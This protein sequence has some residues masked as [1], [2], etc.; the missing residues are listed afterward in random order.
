MAIAGIAYYWIPES[1]IYL[2]AMER[3]E[4][5]R[6][7]IKTIAHYNRVLMPEFYYLEEARKEITGKSSKLPPINISGFWMMYND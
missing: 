4:D 3:Y 5:S 6:N 2:Y 7:S 1:P